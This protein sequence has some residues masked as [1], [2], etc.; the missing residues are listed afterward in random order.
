[1]TNISL[2]KL[3]ATLLACMLG[4]AA[5]TSAGCAGNSANDR[6]HSTQDS[7]SDVGF[8]VQNT[9]NAPA[10]DV[11]AADDVVAA[12]AEAGGRVT[13]VVA[14]SDPSAEVADFSEGKLASSE[15]NRRKKASQIA[16][17]WLAAPADSPE[18]DL[19]GSIHL[20]AR[21]LP[22]DSAIIVYSSALSTAGTVDFRSG[23]VEAD[24]EEV[25]A[26]YVQAGLLP[27]LS[28][29]RVVWY[30]IGDVAA[31][32]ATPSIAQATRIRDIWSA[33]LG[34]CGAEVE[35]RDDAVACGRDAAEALP[36]VTTVD[37]P[38]APTFKANEKVESLT[39]TD[40][41]L[42]FQGDSSEF[43]DRDAASAV[44]AEVADYMKANPQAEATVLGS[45]ATCTWRDGWAQELSEMR[46]NAV[47]D[48]LVALGVERSRLTGVGLGDTADDHVN[49]IDPSTGLQVPEKAAL[50]RK[51]VIDFIWKS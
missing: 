12:A 17:E 45:T 8:V 3:L 50:N 42:T 13:V 21:G 5:L 41:I 27:D 48:A 37:M 2:S 46:A 43:L 22:S 20:A 15:L 25:T 24:P 39:L 6:N 51:V 32:Q 26:F 40:S 44:L 29:Y 11:S 14:D 23:L 28:G 30:G 4:A 36:E 18:V 38:A 33:I 35:F 1:M 47:V 10:W 16:S 19:L 31:P 34:A 7:P 9:A 49:D